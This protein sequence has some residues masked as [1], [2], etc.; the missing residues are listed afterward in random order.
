MA[1]LPG[2]PIQTLEWL[3]RRTGQF[4]HAVGYW[5]PHQHA[6]GLMWS[7]LARTP[8]RIDLCVTTRSERFAQAVAH[9]IEVE[10]W[11]I[12]YVFASA[13]EDL[14]RRL[15]YSPDAERVY[16]G[17]ESQRWAYGP[18]GYFLSRDAPIT[19]S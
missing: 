5:K 10:N 14:G 3:A 13:P 12:S 15:P 17:L 11:P 8:L 16:Y 9:K 1:V 7:L 19:V 6:L 18:Q 4:D 2:R